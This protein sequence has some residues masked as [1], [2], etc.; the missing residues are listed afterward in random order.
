MQVGQDVMAGARHGPGTPSR[1][2]AAMAALT[3]FEAVPSRALAAPD[4]RKQEP[5]ATQTGIAGGPISWRSVTSEDAEPLRH[6]AEQHG[7]RQHRIGARDQ[8][9]EPAGLG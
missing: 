6:H 2:G 8:H 3:M 5:P 1:A 4:D 7:D 9:G